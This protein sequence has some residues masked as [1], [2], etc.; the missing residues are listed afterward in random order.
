MSFDFTMFHYNNVPVFMYSMIGLTVGAIVLSSSFDTASDN[1]P[2]PETITNALPS[3]SVSPI[4]TTTVGGSKRLN[5]T[6][7]TGHKR[8]H[9]S[10]SRNKK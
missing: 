9:N 2:V 4:I 7:K 10:T 3:S 6:K 8:H 5:K 1:L